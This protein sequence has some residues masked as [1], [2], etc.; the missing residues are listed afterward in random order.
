MS[1]R[2]ALVTCSQFPDLFD[3]DR[4]LLAALR[5]EG[6]DG[7]PAVW[8]D[9]GVDWSAYDVAVIRSTWDYHRRYG[10]FGRWLDRVSKSTRLWNPPG[11]V[12]WNS[13]KSYLRD[14]RARDVPIVPTEWVGST[15][16]VRRA[17]S[18]HRWPKYVVKP[19]V[20]ANAERTLLLEVGTEVPTLEDRGDGGWMVQPYVPEVE[21]VGERSM[22]YL[23]GEYSHAVQRK[24]ALNPA[25]GLIDGASV[26]PTPAERSAAERA[27]RA[28]G[29]RTLYA[30]ADLV[31]TADGVVRVMEL[32][33]VEPLLY[34]RAQEGAAAR[35]ARGIAERLT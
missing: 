18:A 30:R 24:A 25:A 10:E 27:V 21:G 31:T 1:R 32:E 28:V 9:D 35:L 3:D 19:T 34:L 4:L 29:G 8:S 12:R 15:D 33:L 2:V 22:I 17:V 23:D 20:S 7:S 16:D 26:I 13:H 6:V 14:L 11:M 5:V